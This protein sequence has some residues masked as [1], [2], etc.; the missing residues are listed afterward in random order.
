LRE[1]DFEGNFGDYEEDKKRH[2]GPDPVEPK[3]IKYK[4]F[5]R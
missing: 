4:K 3:Q 1:A 2:L 5:A